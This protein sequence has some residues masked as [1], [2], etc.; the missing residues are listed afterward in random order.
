MPFSSSATI[1]AMSLDWS[2]V[3]ATRVV[4]GS[5]GS[6]VTAYQ[7]DAERI[8]AFL[9]VNGQSK[10]AEVARQTGV[11][12]ATRMMA[13]N[14]YGWFCRVSTGIYDLTEAGA[15]AVQAH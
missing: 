2:L 3:Y 14:H 5:R 7:Q 10:G 6:I 12:R 1:I 13:D 15:K 8:A 9:A 11:A 4:G